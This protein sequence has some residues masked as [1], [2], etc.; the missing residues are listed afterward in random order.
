MGFSRPRC[1]QTAHSCFRQLYPQRAPLPHADDLDRA[2]PRFSSSRCS[3]AS[4]NRKR[5]GRK[6]PGSDRPNGVNHPESSTTPPLTFSQ[7]S[8]GE[9]SMLPLTIHIQS[10]LTRKPRGTA[11]PGDCQILLRPQH[12]CTTTTHSTVKLAESDLFDAE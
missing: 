5:E 10:R 7:Q 11:A 3:A 9:A 2:A 4:L 6:Q 12:A 1:L 8:A